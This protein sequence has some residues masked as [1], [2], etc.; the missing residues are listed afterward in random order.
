MAKNPFKPGRGHMP[1]LMAGR[2]AAKRGINDVLQHLRAPSTGSPRDIILYGPRGNGKTVLLKWM[3]E[4]CAADLGYQV[5]RITP[6][7]TMSLKDQLMDVMGDAQ[8]QV[9]TERSASL[10]FNLLKGL[11]KRSIVQSSRSKP[12]VGYL[13]DKANERPLVLLVDEAHTMSKEWGHELLNVSQEVCQEEVPFLVVYAGT[14][15]LEEHLGTM[16]ATFWSRSKII[17]LG[18]LDDEAAADAIITPLQNDDISLGPNVLSQVVAASQGYPYFIQHWG[19]S[20]WETVKAADSH[21]ID[22]AILDEASR[23]FNDEKHRHYKTIYREILKHDLVPAALSIARAIEGRDEITDSDLH[24]IV[25]GEQ[26]WPSP[27]Q[28]VKDTISALTQMGYIWQGSANNVWQ[29][30]I[31]TLMSYV[32]SVN[33]QLTPGNSSDFSPG[34]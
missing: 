34:M 3:H 12:L 28:K 8:A 33:P 15:G 17:P 21:M 22:Q 26:V 27:S 9:T 2:D 11:V 13:I 20:L 30:G 14:P 25:A 5:I 24:N 6:S 4:R 1:P 7:D 19:A 16:E 31:P 18:L 23:A 10:G 29:L 32:Q